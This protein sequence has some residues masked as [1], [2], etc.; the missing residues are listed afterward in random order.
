MGA[1]TEHGIEE[2]EG[3]LFENDLFTDDEIGLVEDYFEDGDDEILE[4][5][6]YREELDGDVYDV[7]AVLKKELRWLIQSGKEEDAE[8]VCRFICSVWELN[9]SYCFPGEMFSENCRVL[10]SEPAM[11]TALF[12]SY[13]SIY[14]SMMCKSN[15]KKLMD[16]AHNDPEIVKKAYGYRGKSIP[17]SIILLTVYFLLKY[18]E[19]KPEDEAGGL[20]A[21]LERQ[22]ITGEEAEQDIALMRQYEDQLLKIFSEIY[23][24]KRPKNVTDEIEKAIRD[25]RVDEEILKM[26]VASV[27]EHCGKIYLNEFRRRHVGG[28]AFINYAL[29]RLL[30]NIVLVCFAARA[31]EML[32]AIACMDMR[33][34]FEDRGG[35]YDQIFGVDS[36]WLIRYA[37]KRWEEKILKEQFVRNREIYLKCMD[38]QNFTL[39]HDMSEVIRRTDPGFHKEREQEE[40]ARQQ[41][42]LAAELVSSVDSNFDK[43][44]EKYLKDQIRLEALYP[45]DERSCETRNCFD[46]EMLSRYRKFYGYDALCKKCEAVLMICGGFDNYGYLLEEGVLK[47]ERVRKLF[48]TMDEMKLALRFQLKGFTYLYGSLPNSKKW[49]VP[50]LTVG[51]EIF[52]AYLQERP[53][54]MRRA[55]RN[56]ERPGRLIALQIYSQG[57]ECPSAEGEQDPLMGQEPSLRQDS[58]M[59]E[60]LRF[61]Q[62]PSKEVRDA[63]VDILCRA[64]NRE[65]DVVRLLSSQA[66]EERKTAVRVLLRWEDEKYALILKDAFFK[67]KSAELRAWLEAVLPVDKLI[68]LE[69]ERGLRE[70][71]K[72]LHKGNKK[73]TLAWT[74]E[75]P[76]SKVHKKD[77]EEADEEYLQAILLA[78]AAMAPRGAMVP[79]GVSSTAEALAGQLDEREY[80][81]Y[82]NEL[83]EKWIAAGADTKKR[84]VLFAAANHGDADMPGRLFEAVQE[85]S[86]KRVPIALEAVRALCLSLRPDALLMVEELSRKFKI[87]KIREAARK[88]LESTASWLGL[89]KEGLMDRTV[90]D[91]GFHE[92]RERIFDYGDRKF[93]V[94]IN[95]EF[96]ARVFDESGKMLKS[97]PA[98]GKRDDEAKAGA[99]REEFKQLKKQIKTMVKSQKERLE[100]ALTSGRQWDIGSWKKL[101]LEN[102]VMF[103]LATGLIWGFYEEGEPAAVFHFMEDG[104][105]HME[106]TAGEPSTDEG[107]FRDKKAFMEGEAFIEKANSIEELLSKKGCSLSEGAKVG[108]VHPLELSQASLKA[109][110]EHLEAHGIVQPIEQLDRPV[111]RMTGE[112]AAEMDLKRFKGMIMR[113]PPLKK[114]L[115]V[116]GWNTDCAEEIYLKENQEL[117]IGVELGM[118]EDF[119]FYYKIGA[120][121]TV[122]LYEVKFYDLSSKED[123]DFEYYFLKDVPERYFSEVVL[124]LTRMTA[125][126]ERRER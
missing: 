10:E 116:L 26:A 105:Y 103:R 40:L 95:A 104:A 81:V 2:I 66:E 30:K 109:W 6:E 13:I 15:L 121:G 65:A 35:S 20:E 71:I 73:R 122:T 62:D 91:L 28:M 49:Q 120:M 27:P 79:F 68:R 77:G 5:L 107:A 8:R 63:L 86:G 61:C 7:K 45:S 87:N 47:A 59:E 58:S 23:Y 54:E 111:Y 85:W 18:P 113:E 76:F 98:P 84:W 119:E 102:P 99:A 115:Q 100:T 75:T 101:F 67:E 12:V 69:G 25:D 110:K 44:V 42:E 126:C 88:A 60:V 70:L 53:D 19:V 108:L 51:K 92:K 31:D 112:E 90:P 1:K 94:D 124:E 32:E 34:D 11:R 14:A 9:A 117:S 41:G 43:K 78:Y 93:I 125:D 55:F 50:F 16:Y 29:S 38:E 52:G 57:L 46:W 4:K 123:Y 83:F 21:L 82:I 48:R 72:E 37:V 96:E 89:T 106:G 64:R 114:R 3:I 118:E 39:Y 74:C 36:Y 97:L 80:A 33:G 56:A 24:Y 22:G 17:E